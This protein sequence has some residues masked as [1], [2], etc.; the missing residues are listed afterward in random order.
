MTRKKFFTYVSQKNNKMIFRKILI[1]QLIA[2]FLVSSCNSET[3][4]QK[5]VFMDNFK[6][7]EEFEM[8]KEYDKKI[9]KDVNLD[10]LKIDELGRQINAEKNIKIQEQ[11]KNEFY[12]LQKAFDTKFGELSE[13]YTAEVSKRLNVYIKEFGKV[14][15]YDII[16]GTSGQGNVMYIDTN[17]NITNELIKFIN[18]EYNK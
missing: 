3:K 10:R 5:I 17:S 15:K 9:E 16:L 1:I 6:V 12:K 2:F 11:Y 14:K 7:F 8:K 18:I 4:T 13:K